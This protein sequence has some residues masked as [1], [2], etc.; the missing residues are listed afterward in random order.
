MGTAACAVNGS[1]NTRYGMIHNIDE[2]IGVLLQSWPKSADPSSSKYRMA[3]VSNTRWSLV[4]FTGGR[5]PDW[6]L[7]DLGN[8]YGQQTDVAASH[9]EVVREL[10][11]TFDRWW[12]DCLPRMVNENAVGPKLNPFAV[13]YRKQ[14]GGGPTEKDYE[15]MDPA[16]PWPPRRK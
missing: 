7:F 16:K 12:Q 11:A 14:F 2:N 6:Q 15:R 4:S 3:A 13:R 1:A 5:E 8:D 9:P 10:A